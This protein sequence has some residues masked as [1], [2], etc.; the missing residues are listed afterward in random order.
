MKMMPEEG[1]ERR[2]ERTHVCQRERTRTHTSLLLFA[3]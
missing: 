2:R 3:S 1:Q